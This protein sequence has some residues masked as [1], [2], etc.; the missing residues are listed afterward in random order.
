MLR[1]PQTCEEI[2]GCSWVL[3]NAEKALGIRSSQFYI[4]LSYSSV[5]F[6]SAGLFDGL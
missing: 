4:I 6:A 1:E 3:E 2:T 5:Y